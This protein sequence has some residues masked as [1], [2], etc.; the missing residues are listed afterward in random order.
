MKNVITKIIKFAFSWPLTI[1]IFIYLIK[2]IDFAEFVG[3]ISKMN[4]VYVALSGILVSFATLYLGV[5]KYRYILKILGYNIS[6]RDVFILR[7]GGFPVKFIFPFKSGE[8]W[9]MFY[10]K[11]VGNVEYKKA[12]YSIVINWVVRLCQLLA[13]GIFFFLIYKRFFFLSF[14]LLLIFIIFLKFF[15]K[16]K[17]YVLCFFYS[18]FL[19]LTLVL[20][21]YFIFMA[22]GVKLD[23]SSFYLTI[24]LVLIIEAL[25]LG[26]GGLG[27]REISIISLFKNIYGIE[28]LFS[29]GLVGSFI[30]AFVPLILGLFFVN[31]FLLETM[32]SSYDYL[33][34]REKNPIT[35]YR[36]NKRMGEILKTLKNIS[37]NRKLKILDIGA[38][39]GKMMAFLKSKLD[40]IVDIAGIEPDERYINAKIDDLNIVKAG[41]E[42]I[43]FKDSEF[44]AVVLASVIEH[45]GD[46][47]NG[48]IEIKRVLKKEGYI[49]ISFVNPFLDRIATLMGF[50]PDDHL[51]R[52]T[53]KEMTLFLRERGFNIIETK[54]FGPLFYNLVVAEK[55]ND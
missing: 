30:N 4:W 15:I 17:D 45:I 23:M 31:R 54:S 35:K 5:Q 2:K 26:V 11:K 18:L 33:K 22:G 41:C 53:K 52:F 39:D 32:F 42:K 36:I 19:E 47:E 55:R 37:Q 38:N 6:F 16:N 3:I 12:I 48:M 43:P 29:I 14:L 46:I 9:R 25:P 7:V 51:R 40:N 44:D 49:I 50:K 24:P 20:S 10:L 13:F 8:I 1:I 28:M 27:L 34:K 21:Y